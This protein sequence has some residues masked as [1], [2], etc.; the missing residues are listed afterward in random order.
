MAIHV[1]QT[2]ENNQNSYLKEQNSNEF[3][4]IL[5]QKMN[6]I[7]YT[8]KDIIEMNQ[9]QEQDQKGS[10]QKYKFN[11]EEIKQMANEIFNTIMTIYPQINI[12]TICYNSS[13]I[14][15]RS[16]K[17][18]NG[19]MLYQKILY[20]CLWENNPHINNLQRVRVSV[21]GLLWK[22]LEENEKTYFKNQAQII[23]YRNG[24]IKKEDKRNQ[25][26]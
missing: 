15:H 12:I 25:Q 23:N 10:S 17:K 24:I 18:L 13:N 11:R 20:K 21:N 19:F 14:E 7:N 9:D 6:F 8:V 16:G 3:P 1:N 5:K 26:T 22:K 2:H 4:T